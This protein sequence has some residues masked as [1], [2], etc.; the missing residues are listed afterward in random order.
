MERKTLHLNLVNEKLAIFSD[1][2]LTAKFDQAKFDFL[3]DLVSKVD[4]VIINGDFW[5]FGETSFEEFIGLQWQALFH[6]L[7]EKST[8]YLYGNHDPARKADQR[9]NL[10]STEQGDECRLKVGQKNLL[11]RHGHLLAPSGDIA[12]PKVFG[13]VK[14]VSFGNIINLFGVRVLGQRY[15]NYFA[16]RN[17]KMKLFAQNLSHD[18]ILVCGHA[19]LQEKNLDKNFINTGVIR[20]GRGQYLLIN[21]E[22]VKLVDER[23]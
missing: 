1:T 19:H 4:R 22:E 12:H 7:K 16:K 23:Y 18:Q 20:W 15:L 2:H 9:V 5:D 6:L 21:G 11:I 10:F 13:S 17:K 3:V 14:M 8:Y